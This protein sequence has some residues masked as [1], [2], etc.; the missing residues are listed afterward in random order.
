M[1][2]A[3]H[4]V[5]PE[6]IC[7]LSVHDK[8]LRLIS[9]LDGVYSNEFLQPRSFLRLLVAIKKMLFKSVDF[10]PSAKVS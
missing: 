5:Q 4:D 3:V 7:A 6:P 2:H 1:V 10:K 8:G 9:H